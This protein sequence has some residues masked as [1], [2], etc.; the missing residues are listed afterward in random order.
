MYLEKE[1]GLSKNSTRQILTIGKAALNWAWKRGEITSVPYIELVKVPTP[2]PKGRPMEAE[3]VATLI[4]NA[5]YHLKAF[6]V[7]MLSATA[8]NRAILDLKFSQID[9]RNELVDLNPQG[10]EQN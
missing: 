2:P 5:E 4:D 10:R 7:L 6:I 3:E 9:F 8:R 1:L